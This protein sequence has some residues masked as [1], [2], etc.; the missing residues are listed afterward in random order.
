MYLSGFEVSLSISVYAGHLV[1]YLLV[2]ATIPI[3]RSIGSK[4]LHKVGRSLA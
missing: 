3:F 1:G 4:E 2:L